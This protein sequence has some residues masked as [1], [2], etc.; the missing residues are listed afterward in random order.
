MDWLHWIGKSYYTMNSFAKEAE[1]YGVSRRISLQTAKQMAW[2]DTVYT[3]ML[4]GKTGVIFGYFNIERITGLSEEASELI[5][6]SHDSTLSGEGGVP[7]G[8]G[9]GSYVTGPSWQVEA[10]IKE[11]VETVE[12][13]KRDSIDEG[14]I[15]V[16]GTFAKIEKIRILDIPFRQGFR[17]VDGVKLLLSFY[18][19]GNAVHGQFYVDSNIADPAILPGGFSEVS[20]TDTPQNPSGEIQEII[21]YQ[22][23]TNRR[24]KRQHRAHLAAQLTLF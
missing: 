18:E 5:V 20:V 10:S 15:M 19:Q 14:Q 8:R 9:C 24:K 4:D 6:E 16:A 22:Q 7:V 2:G 12:E 21:D 13:V 23:N 11:I 3:A 17:K 1:M